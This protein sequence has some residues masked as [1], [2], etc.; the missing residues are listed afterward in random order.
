MSRQWDYIRRVV[1][2]GK[3]VFSEKSIAENIKDA[4][5]LIQWYHSHTEQ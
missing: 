3:H 4:Q 5:E 2:A 1:S